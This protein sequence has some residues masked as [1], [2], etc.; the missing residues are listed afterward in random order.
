MSG[1][2]SAVDL[3]VYVHVPFCERVCPYCDFAVEAVGR[4]DAAPEAEYVALVLRELELVRRALGSDLEGRRLATVYFGGGTPSL[5]RGASIERVLQALDAAFAGPAAEVTLEL[6]PGVLEIARIPEF[7]TAGITRLSVG[8]Q[9][10]HDSTLKRLGRGHSAA[11]ALGGLEACVRAGFDS[12][13]VDLIYGAPE[14]QTAELLADVDRVMDLG[15]PHVSAY[16]LTLEAGTPFAA[17]AGA[18]RLTLPGEDDALRM[19]Q[20]LRSRLAGGRYRQ[21][22]ISSFARHGHR[23]GHNQRYWLR[24]DVL[25]LGPSA[26]SLLG[27]RRF[28]NERGRPAWEAALAAGRR[29][30]ASCERLTAREVRQE[31]FALGLRRLDGVSRAAYERRFGVSPEADFGPE[32]AE[33]RGL[34]LVAD[35]AGWL[36][37]TQRGILFA[38]EVFLRFVGR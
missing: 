31:T 2:T 6:N 8:V 28:Q 9:S 1:P 3:G 12:L 32:L 17:A 38:D 30:L 5:L 11:E 18:G 27:Q 21:Y 36:A 13:S 23:S 34:G 24:R 15:V 29:P 10:L 20:L 7:R 25:G 26:A 37:L 35:R 33:L 22:E 16:A 19:G 14:Q 4:L